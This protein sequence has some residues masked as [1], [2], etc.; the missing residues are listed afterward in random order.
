MEDLTPS[1]KYARSEKGRAVQK[2][3]RE[4]E[5]NKKIKKAWRD[6]GGSAQEYQRNRDKYR[7]TY[8]KRFYG[9]SLEEYNNMTEQQ[10]GLCYVCNQPPKGGKRLAVD[11]CH[12]TGAV[13]RLLCGNCNTTLGLVNEDINIMNKLIKYIEEHRCS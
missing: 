4:T 7:D 13:R 10:N 11:H 1:Q 5:Q 3:I 2:K 6:N 12:S 9:L 8:L